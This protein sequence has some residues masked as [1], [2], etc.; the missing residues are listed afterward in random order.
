[1]L[2][3]TKS[4]IGQVMS[5][6]GK[7]GLVTFARGSLEDEAW[8]ERELTSCGQIEYLYHIAAQGRD[9]G[10]WEDYY[11]AN[12]VVTRN[13]L[14]V[15]V[16]RCP[17]LRRF[18]H[19]STV[20][21]YGSSRPTSECNEDVFVSSE[22]HAFY[23]T[24]KV[25]AERL[26]LKAH[27]QRNLP[28][29]ILRPSV[30]F[31]PGSWSWGLEEAQLMYQGKG[32]LINH[33]KATCGA[34]FIDDLVSALWMAA[35]S[36]NTIGNIYNICDN[37]DVPW[38]TY[39]KAISDGI[40]LPPIKRSIPYW[41]AYLVAFISEWVWW[42]L[43]KKNR[44]VLTLFV[45]ALIGRDQKYPTQ[46]ANT[47]FGWRPRVPFQEAMLRTTRWLLETKLYMQE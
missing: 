39:F 29:T 17:K 2:L 26:V 4:D 23:S 31:G 33:G 45:L 25:L 42:L 7:T 27:A 9:W 1:M 32:V 36:P 5:N 38:A 28:I 19:V 46:N 10:P 20:D 13:L 11:N 22:R 30:V 6:V 44:P 40:G 34:I 43:R 47:D 21:V 12:V 35:E 24:T 3:R 18:L 16:K 15:A 8:V 14:D 41:L 37:T